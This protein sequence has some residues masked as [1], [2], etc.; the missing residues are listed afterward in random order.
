MEIV[1]DL[2]AAGF[3]NSIG[4][5]VYDIHSPRVPGTDEIVD[6]LRA[7][8]SAVGSDRLWVNPDCGLKTRKTD[9]V[10]AALR[11]MVDA[12]KRVRAEV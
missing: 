8:L 7:A 4:P 9:E 1:E 11:N 10:E 5:G 6:G 2:T 3:G 12:A